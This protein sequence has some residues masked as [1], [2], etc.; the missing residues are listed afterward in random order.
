MPSE[1]GPCRGMY[2]RFAYDVA[3][4][5]CV[6]FNYG[7]CRGNKNNFYS[8]AECQQTCQRF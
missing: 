6:P 3:Q 2:D 1:E 7:G 4:R 5:R 8:L